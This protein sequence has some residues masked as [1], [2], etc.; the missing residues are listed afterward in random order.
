[1]NCRILKAFTSSGEAARVQENTSSS[2]PDL[3]GNTV[4]ELYWS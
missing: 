1:M 3:G 4:L 2:T